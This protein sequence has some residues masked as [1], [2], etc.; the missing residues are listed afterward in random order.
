MASLNYFIS[1]SMITTKEGIQRSVIVWDDGLTGE[2]D[3]ICI[4]E[5]VTIVRDQ[6]EYGWIKVL[7]PR[8]TIGFVHKTN[9]RSPLVELCKV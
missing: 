8:G 4:N 9:V 7:T 3:K 1:G 6:D 5:L 2:V